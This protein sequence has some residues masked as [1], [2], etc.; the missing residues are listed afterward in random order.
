VSDGIAPHRG[1]RREIIHIE[2]RALRG[3]SDRLLAG[4][5]KDTNGGQGEGQVCKENGQR[6]WWR[7]SYGDGVGCCVCGGRGRVRDHERGGWCEGHG[8]WRHTIPPTV[9]TYLP[10]AYAQ[11]DPFRRVHYRTT[12][13]E[14]SECALLRDLSPQVLFFLLSSRRR[15]GVCSFGGRELLLRVRFPGCL[16]FMRNEAECG[17]PSAIVEGGEGK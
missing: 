14:T 5:N 11:R 15:W 13:R 3:K 6:G 7:G 1:G 2:P 10:L 17:F 8:E 9:P 4:T 12:T 16:G